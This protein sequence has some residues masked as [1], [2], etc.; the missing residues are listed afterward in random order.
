MTYEVQFKLRDAEYTVRGPDTAGI[1]ALID[2]LQP[3]ERR[4]DLTL[5]EL[6]ASMLAQETVPPVSSAECRD[7]AEATLTRMGYT[8]NGGVLWHPPIGPAPAF[9]ET[10]LPPLEQPEQ[11]WI[12]MDGN[13]R[14]VRAHAKVEVQF[15][16]GMCYG[17][18]HAHAVAWEKVMAYRLMGREVPPADDDW[19]DWAG[20]S[21]PVRA[22]A[23]VQVRLKDGFIAGAVPAHTV[24]WDGPLHHAHSIVAYKVVTPCA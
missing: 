4:S 5:G 23:R 3:K 20:G 11:G 10:P 19:I 6:Y 7:A 12:P 15:K 9:D 8:W 14:P 13:N 17:P 18:L 24:A 21:C 2:G 22:H 16:S 1:L